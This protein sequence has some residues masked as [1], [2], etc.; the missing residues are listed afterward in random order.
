ME[1][2][3]RRCASR[4]SKP[5][6]TTKS[7]LPPAALAP[8]AGAAPCQ[9]TKPPAWIPEGLPP[10]DP[11]QPDLDPIPPAG[12]VPAAGEEMALVDVGLALESPPVA[13]PGLVSY[14]VQPQPCCSVVGDG[15]VV[16]VPVQMSAAALGPVPAEDVEVVPQSPLSASSVAGGLVSGDARGTGDG[17]ME[18]LAPLTTA[19]AVVCL[20]VGADSVSP[21]CDPADAVGDQSGDGP[22]IFVGRRRQPLGHGACS[23]APDSSALLCP[24]LEQAAA[25]RRRTHGRCFRCLAPDHKAAFCRDPIR[26]LACLRSGHRE[27]DCGRRRSSGRAPRRNAR[28]P[29]APPCPS[30]AGRSWASVVAPAM[31]VQAAESARFSEAPSEGGVGHDVVTKSA[32]PSAELQT[33][34]ELALRPLRR[35]EDSLCLWLAR[36][37]SLLERAEESNGVQGSTLAAQAPQLAKDGDQ[38]IKEDGDNAQLMRSGLVAPMES[39][40]Q[41]ASVGAMASSDKVASDF[42]LAFATSDEVRAVAEGCTLVNEGEDTLH[43]FTELFKGLIAVP[44]ITQGLCR[45]VNGNKMKNVNQLVSAA[46]RDNPA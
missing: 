5:A 13:A 44:S 39:A 46:V 7:A 3:G 42:S 29:P 11:D 33:M 37:T 38:G 21:A 24:R 32:S 8:L 30:S 18:G 15:E 28:V 22:W 2:G 16:D 34:M 31:H 27:R 10:L 35:L 43:D 9:L 41:V 4:P 23:Q 12:Q 20:T 1:N 36:A 6:T 17:V 40:G 26:C 14:A 19:P 45:L 25:F